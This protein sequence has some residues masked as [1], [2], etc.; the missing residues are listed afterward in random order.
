M[1]ALSLSLGSDAYYT[2]FGC[3]FSLSAA[4][5]RSGKLAAMEAVIADCPPI[6]R[7]VIELPDSYKA[8]PEAAALATRFA[9]RG[10]AV[11]WSAEP[12]ETLQ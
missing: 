10:V 7:L 3:G 8:A 9:E 1:L 4:L 12:V 2:L 11:A 5:P 6:A